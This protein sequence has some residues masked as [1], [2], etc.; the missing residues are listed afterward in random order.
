MS[1]SPKYKRILLKIGGESLLGKREYGID[2]Q[3]ALDVA[4][5]IKE[6][7]DLGVQVALV[8]GAGNIFRGMPAAAN[9]MDRATAD[10]MGMLATIMNSLA[11][12][13]ALE[14]SGV[15]TRVQ[16][17]IEMRA[18]AEPFVR[19]RALRHMEKGR[20]VILAAGTGSPYF[21]TDSGAAL[22]ALELN[23]DILLKG[24]KVDGVYDKDPVKFPDAKRFETMT[25][26]DAIKDEMVQVMDT[27][28]LSL[29]MDNDI[30]IYVF[31]LFE[32]GNLYRAVMGETIGTL[33]SGR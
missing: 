7:H 23:C 32:T 26:L 19:R 12:Q 25:Y 18:V 28:A 10:Y 4:K 6:I 8:I 29:C 11:M 30:P 24:T 14:K 16:T 20:V 1:T 17:A 2:A 22:R 21:T 9:G 5:Q 31:N 15:D 27:A 33:V 3:A 13:D